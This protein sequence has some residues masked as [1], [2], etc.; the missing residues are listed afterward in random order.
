M[1]YHTRFGCSGSNGET[2]HI[3]TQDMTKLEDT[4][5]YYYYLLLITNYFLHEG[6]CFHSVC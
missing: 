5:D 6:G 2:M 4:K 3:R 1:D